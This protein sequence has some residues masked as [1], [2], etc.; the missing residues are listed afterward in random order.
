[1]EEQDTIKQTCCFHPGTGEGR[2]VGDS[3]AHRIDP[4]AEYR[5]EEISSPRM[6]RS[7][8]VQ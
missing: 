3:I 8:G 6:M 1:M 7:A 5:D 2:M 4:M